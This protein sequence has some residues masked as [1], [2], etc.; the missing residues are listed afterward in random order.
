MVFDLNNLK[1]INDTFGHEA[2]DR[3]IINSCKLIAQVYVG[4][5]IYRVGGD[6]FS[7]ILEGENYEKRDELMEEFNS[8]IDK[9]VRK[10]HSIIISAGMSVFAPGKDSSI[11]QVFTRADV[12]MYKRKHYIK[13]HNP[14]SGAE[15]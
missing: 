6:E 11:I 4:V 7:V 2:G 1:N 14:N 9:N 3:Y 15:A 12:E 5:P 8:L 13:D 10:H